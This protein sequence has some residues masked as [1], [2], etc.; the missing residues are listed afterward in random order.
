MP[1]N[2]ADLQKPGEKKANFAPRWLFQTQFQILDHFFH[3]DCFQQNLNKIGPDLYVGLENEGEV[4]KKRNFGYSKVLGN[5]SWNQKSQRISY[6]CKE[7]HGKS[8]FG[9]L[10]AQ[11]L[12]EKKQIE[13]TFF[14]KR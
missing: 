14:A 1:A 3:F 5:C 4:E 2:V 7:I 6:Q 8:I 9:L 12:L 11:K 10:R 13:H